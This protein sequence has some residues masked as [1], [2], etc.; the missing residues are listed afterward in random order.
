VFIEGESVMF[1]NNSIPNT[2]P[3][4]GRVDWRNLQSIN[5]Q[6]VELMMK[7]KFNSP[8]IQGNQAYQGRENDPY[9]ELQQ[10]LSNCSSTIKQKIM[11]D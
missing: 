2:A 5:P 7:Q 3:L 8:F 4:Y 1:N 6:E 10:L 11:E 9:M